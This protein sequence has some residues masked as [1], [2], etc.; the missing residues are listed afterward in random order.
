[1]ER[2]PAYCLLSLA[3]FR[4]AGGTVTDR[5]VTVRLHDISRGGRG[6]D[7][8][9]WVASLRSELPEAGLTRMAKWPSVCYRVR[10]F[11]QV[12]S[13]FVVVSAACLGHRG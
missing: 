7:G 11:E 8:V 12:P 4:G 1:M 13:L 2:A 10:L 5:Q 3:G 6:E 9:A